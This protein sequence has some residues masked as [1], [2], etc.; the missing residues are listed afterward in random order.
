M[1]KTADGIARQTAGRIAGQTAGRKMVKLLII[2]PHNTAGQTAA[3]Q[4]SV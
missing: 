1:I 3:S 2:P 4:K